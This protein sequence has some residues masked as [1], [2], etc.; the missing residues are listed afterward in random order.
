MTVYE[1]IFVSGKKNFRACLISCFRASSCR[2]KN[3]EHD[4]KKISVVD[5]DSWSSFHQQ[6]IILFLRSMF[7]VLVLPRVFVRRSYSSF[8]ANGIRSIASKKVSSLAQLQPQLREV[9]SVNM[10][11]RQP[12]G[13]PPVNSGIPSNVSPNDLSPARHSSGEAEISPPADDGR[14]RTAPPVAAAPDNVSAAGG[15]PPASLAEVS[16]QLAD[17]VDAR[18]WEQFHTPRNLVLALTGEVGELAEIFQWKSDAKCGVGLPGFSEAEKQHVG[19]ELAD[20]FSYLVRLSDVCGVDL[21]EAWRAKM[22]KN[23]NKYP[24]EKCRGSA[25]KYTKY[26]GGGVGA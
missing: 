26:S 13:P 23:R 22:E 21:L 10:V 2:P 7:P 20:V 8:P 4:S 25:D 3:C 16:T 17:M 24:V 15:V 12:V 11:S 1:K 14:T 9:S 5:H 6:G 19:E 18:D